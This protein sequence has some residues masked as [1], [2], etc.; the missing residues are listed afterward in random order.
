[1]KTRFGE[2]PMLFAYVHV[3]EFAAQALLRTRLRGKRIAMLE[4]AAAHE[5]VCAVNALAR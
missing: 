2:A 1:M 3:P 5:Q 4:D